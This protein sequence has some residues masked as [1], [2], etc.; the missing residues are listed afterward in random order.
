M[1]IYNYSPDNGIFIGAAEADESPLEEGV[2]LIPANATTT[3]PPSTEIGQQAVF[4]NG[5]WQVLVIPTPSPPT[6][7]Q[8]IAKYESALD[9]HLDAVAVA[10]RYKDRFTFALR[11]GYPGPYHDEGAAFAAWMDTCN[12]QAFA[13]LQSVQSGAAALPTIEDFIAALP[14]FVL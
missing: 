4:S 1:R 11:A 5:A 2:W 6:Q 9:A 7:E 3:P 12:V 13:L 14:E 10:Y 8:V